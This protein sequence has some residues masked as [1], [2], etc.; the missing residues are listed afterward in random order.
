MLIP[1][2]VNLI[3]LISNHGNYVHTGVLIEDVSDKESVETNETI[4]N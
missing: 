3:N 4:P 1:T 2:L